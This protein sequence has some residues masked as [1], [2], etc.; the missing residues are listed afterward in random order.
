MKILPCPTM[1]CS[2]PAD[3]TKHVSPLVRPGA[4]GSIEFISLS[5][6]SH[7]VDPRARV[8]RQCPHCQAAFPD[9]HPDNGCEMAD[10]FNTH[11]S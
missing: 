6:V 3:F 11:E 5:F 4:D 10:V 8:Y 2:I 1:G 9:V 7:P